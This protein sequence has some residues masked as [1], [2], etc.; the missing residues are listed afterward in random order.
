MHNFIH[1]DDIIRYYERKNFGKHT[2]DD[3]HQ[4]VINAK[5]KK[6]VGTVEDFRV[7]AE[8]LL[9]SRFEVYYGVE[10]AFDLVF[11]CK[12]C[13]SIIWGGVDER[14]DPYLKCP[15]CSGYNTNLPYW[16]GDEVARDEEKQIDLAIVMEH[17]EYVDATNTRYREEGLYDWEYW[18]REGK[19]WNMATTVQSFYYSG[20]RGLTLYIWK[21]ENS[22]HDGLRIPLSWK[23]VYDLWIYPHTK[24]AKE[25]SKLPF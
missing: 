25:A 16:A 2:I 8:H 11:K 20:K 24:K 12:D 9:N 6:A 10:D 19:K 21:K 5:T 17:S 1:C 22:R 18:R 15:H 3:S 23:S 14:F 7:I 4:Y 13:G